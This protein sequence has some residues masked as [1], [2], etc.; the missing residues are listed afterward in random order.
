MNEVERLPEQPRFF[1][2]IDFKRAVRWNPCRL[3]RTQIYTDYFALRVL[4]RE[5]VNV[6][7]YA[8]EE[9]FFLLGE[10]DGPDPGAC[11]AVQG[12][13]QI[14]WQSRNVE[15]SSHDHSHGMG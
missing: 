6:Y 4:A 7:D 9:S 10:V 2:I 12:S 5:A 8:L 14:L 1:Q 3:Y 11:S 13:M 15:S